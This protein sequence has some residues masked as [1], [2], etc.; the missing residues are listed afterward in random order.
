MATAS[1]MLENENLLLDNG[2]TLHDLCMAYCES[3]GVANMCA[4]V[5]LKVLPMREYAEGPPVNLNLLAQL[6]HC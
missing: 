3:D 1:F 5:E 4:Y 2:Q 6:F